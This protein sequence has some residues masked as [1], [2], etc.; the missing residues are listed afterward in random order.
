M[1]RHTPAKRADQPRGPRVFRIR[2]LECRSD[3]ERNQIGSKLD[4]RRNAAD[5]PGSRALGPHSRVQKIRDVS[6]DVYS[7]ATR[8]RRCRTSALHPAQI[9]GRLHAQRP[10]PKND[11]GAHVLRSSSARGARSPSRST[12][13]CSSALPIRACHARRRPSCSPSTTQTARARSQGCGSC[14]SPI[15]L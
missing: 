4:R 11:R 13:L 7:T 1:E 5:P 14:R 15:A 9:R 10:T 3:A 2:K 6:A 12:R 8:A